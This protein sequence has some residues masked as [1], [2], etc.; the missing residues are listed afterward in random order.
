VTNYE[1]GRQYEYRSMRTLAAAGYEVARAAGSHGPWDIAGFS[2]GGVVLVQVK[3]NC[4]PTAAEIEQL[5]LYPCPPGTTKLIHHWQKR[6][7]E[8]IVRVL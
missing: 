3:F 6:A 1:K 2:A 8:P 5:T 4:Q 7:R